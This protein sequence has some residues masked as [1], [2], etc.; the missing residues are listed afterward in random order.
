MLEKA[1]FRLQLD[2][3][4]QE[5]EMLLKAVCVDAKKALARSCNPPAKYLEYGVELCVKSSFWG[6]KIVP[7]PA[8]NN[9]E[10]FRTA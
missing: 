9:V 1:Y 3:T 8:K 10:A 4:V 2:S 5:I 6:L 7:K